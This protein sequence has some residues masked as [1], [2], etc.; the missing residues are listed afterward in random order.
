M[1]HGWIP[2]NVRS[3]TADPAASSGRTGKSSIPSPELANNSHCTEISGNREAFALQRDSMVG[4]PNIIIQKFG[5]TQS[6]CN[7]CTDFDSIC[8]AKEATG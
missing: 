4:H 5:C 3:A 6:H 2:Q 1:G 8:H 7:S